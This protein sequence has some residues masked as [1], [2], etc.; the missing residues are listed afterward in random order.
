MPPRLVETHCPRCNEP[1]LVR[2]Q[3]DRLRSLCQRCWCISMNDARFPSDVA[4]AKY[5]PLRAIHSG[6]IQRCYNPK[7]K[8]FYRYGGRG[9]AVCQEWRCNAYSFIAWARSHGYEKG[10]LLDRENNDGNYE[11]SNCRWVTPAIS[12]RN[13]RHTKL[14]AEEIPLIRSM[15]A[16][17][18]TNVFIG[19]QF[20]V[21]PR[22]IS[23]IRCGHYWT[24]IQCNA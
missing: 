8:W 10:L 6:M 4:Y 22:T 11:P 21:N 20:G 12:T 7:T 2:N 23:G 15:I 9:I 16:E 3:P 1:R 17:G 13:S 18:R 14:H 5:D 24:D 19:Q